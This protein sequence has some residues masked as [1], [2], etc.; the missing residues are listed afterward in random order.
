MGVGD[1]KDARM[2]EAIAT[3]V[4]AYEL[5]RTPAVGDVFNRSFLPPKGERMLPGVVN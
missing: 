1:V 2:T 3:I 4:A 5:P